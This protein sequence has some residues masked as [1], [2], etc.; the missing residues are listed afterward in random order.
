MHSPIGE[1]LAALEACFLN[2]GRG[3]RALDAATG[4]EHWR[5]AALVG[6]MNKGVALGSGLVFAGLSDSRLITTSAICTWPRYFLNPACHVFERKASVDPNDR[7]R[8]FG[9]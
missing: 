7:T 6:R 9:A 1:V 2:T 8:S 3:I 5:H 4:E